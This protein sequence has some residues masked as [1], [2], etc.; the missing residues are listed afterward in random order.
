MRKQWSTHLTSR[1]ASALPPTGGWSAVHRS[2]VAPARG[3]TASMTASSSACDTVA[4]GAC[5]MRL[6]IGCQGEAMKGHGR[7]RKAV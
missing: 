2:V 5:R 7:L 3:T 1:R 4:S 6:R